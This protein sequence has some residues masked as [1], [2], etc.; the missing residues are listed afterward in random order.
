MSFGRLVVDK[1]C[2]FYE[3]HNTLC[4]FLTP[5]RDYV[6][7]L[8]DSNGYEPF[9]ATLCTGIMC[10][11]KLQP[12]FLFAILDAYIVTIKDFAQRRAKVYRGRTGAE[13][14]WWNWLFGVGTVTRAQLS[15]ELR[16]RVRPFVVGQTLSSSVSELDLDQLQRETNVL[17]NSGLSHRSTFHEHYILYLSII[18]CSY[19]RFMDDETLI[20]AI[21]NLVEIDTN[22]YDNFD[23]DVVV[24]FQ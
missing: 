19:R 20:R 1:Q 22:F 24:E 14:S 11:T 3:L 10:V 18:I 23:S 17:F 12:G 8:L 2:R 5:F 6:D 13:V 21:E 7:P 4:R 9:V 15:Q 16:A